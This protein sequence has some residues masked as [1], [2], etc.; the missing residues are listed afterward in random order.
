MTVTIKPN[1]KLIAQFSDLQISVA[2]T[3]KAGD[4]VSRTKLSESAH[5]VLHS[6]L[7]NN[8]P[9]ITVNGQSHILTDGILTAFWEWDSEPITQNDLDQL[10]AYY[11]SVSETV[12]IFQDLNNKKYKVTMQYTGENSNWNPITFKYGLKC[13]KAGFTLDTDDSVVICIQRNAHI[14]DWNI[15]QVDLDDGQIFDV[16]KIGEDICY[17]IF[18]QRVDVDGTTIDKYSCRNQ[19]S[20]KIKVTNLSNKPCKIIQIYK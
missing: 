5:S 10:S 12:Q 15:R 17:T 11:N 2:D 3:T 18:S 20:E 4:E 8:N 13:G 19:T 14:E 6:T 9:N 7:L 16:E 1:F